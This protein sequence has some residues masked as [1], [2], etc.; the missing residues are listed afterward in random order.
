METMKQ[1]GA[2][3]TCGHKKWKWRRYRCKICEPTKYVAFNQLSIHAA[4]YHVEAYRKC[5]S[6]WEI[7][8]KSSEKGEV[9]N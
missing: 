8:D 1:V 6:L 4:T 5:E 3:P 9:K 7:F 2:C